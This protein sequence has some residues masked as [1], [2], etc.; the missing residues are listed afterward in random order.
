MMKNDLESLKKTLVDEN[1]WEGHEPSE[2][3][4][5]E[6]PTVFLVIGKTEEV[7]ERIVNPIIDDLG[8]QRW[9]EYTRNFEQ[10]IVSCPLVLKTYKLDASKGMES[11]KDQIANNH[12]D[13]EKLNI[14][15]IEPFDEKAFEGQE[16]EFDNTLFRLMTSG[17]SIGSGDIRRDWYNSHIIIITEKMPCSKKCPSFDYFNR[18]GSLRIVDCSVE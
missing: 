12:P 8:N 17:V 18:K 7:Y 10:D 16:M 5:L 13:L 15:I 2:I 11:L 3:S 9:D 4:I 14:Y 6:V 1:Y